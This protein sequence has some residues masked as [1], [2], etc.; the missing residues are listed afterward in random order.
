MLGGYHQLSRSTGI[1]LMLGFLVLLMQGCKPLVDIDLDVSAISKGCA[2]TKGTGDGNGPD[3]PTGCQKADI[4][5]SPQSIINA[6]G[7]NITCVA[8]STSKK[9][10][11]E[12]TTAGCRSGKCTTVNWPTGTTTC[13]CQCK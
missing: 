3:D 10:L 5:P 6:L 2:T 12:G 4:N 7:Q 8:G 1:V 11:S 13:D 9:C